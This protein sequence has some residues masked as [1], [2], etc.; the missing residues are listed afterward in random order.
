MAG[1]REPALA[2]AVPGA[3]REIEGRAGRL[4]YY[5]AGSGRP[6]LLIH[7]INAAGSVYEVKPIFERAMATRRTFAVDL[8][9]FGRSDRS[10]RRYDVAL[11]V[12]AIHDMLDEIARETDEPVDALAVSLASEFLARACTQAPGRLRT[13][14]LVT[15]TGFGRAYHVVPKRQGG[16]REIPGIY[17]FCRLPLWSDALFGL[18]TSRASIRYFLKRTYGGE[19]IDEGMLDYD[20]L[21]THQP[22][23]KHAPLVFVAGR[24]FSA[25]ITAIYQELG[26]PVW[27]P[28]GT[29]GDF[30]DFSGADW[31][32]ARA[33]WTFEAFA[34]GALPQFEEP[35][36]FMAAYERFLAQ[37]SSPERSP[38]P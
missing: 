20:Y 2:A 6:L 38:S 26:L 31:A 9:G 37:E 1:G 18:L 27:V 19:R 22:G 10:D 29:R 33:N 32:R 23:A 4:G 28:H 21:T 15:P 30:R 3:W 13:L 5:V 8:P 17:A 35:E 36:A 16:T 25:D 12:A 11:Y 24:L 14:A 34:T 7:S